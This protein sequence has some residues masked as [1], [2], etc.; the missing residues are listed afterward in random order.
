MQVNLDTWEAAQ[1]DNL[2]SQDWGK[3]TPEML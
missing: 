1:V 2:Q 3:E